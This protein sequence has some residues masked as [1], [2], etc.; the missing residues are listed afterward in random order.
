MEGVEGRNQHN[1]WT[2]AVRWGTGG[3]GIARSRSSSLVGP[4]CM[5][6]PL[7]PLKNFQL[8]RQMSE[9]L[10]DSQLAY[11]FTNHQIL[12]LAL[13]YWSDGGVLLWMTRLLANTMGARYPL[14]YHFCVAFGQSEEARLEKRDIHRWEWLKLT[15]GW[16]LQADKTNGNA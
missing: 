8:R 4:T 9:Q 10:S 16:A 2:H 3:T 13:A 6:C 14:G 5:V 7:A 11:P 12:V 15:S 1:W